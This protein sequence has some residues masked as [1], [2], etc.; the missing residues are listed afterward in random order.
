MKVHIEN[1]YPD[2]VQAQ[3][4]YDKSLSYKWQLEEGIEENIKRDLKI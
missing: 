4:V 2:R 1:K 3:P